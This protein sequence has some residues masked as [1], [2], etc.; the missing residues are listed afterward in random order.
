MI[1]L[2]S[3]RLGLSASLVLTVHRMACHGLKSLHG[4]SDREQVMMERGLTHDWDALSMTVS[5]DK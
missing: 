3:S 4:V 2:H 1:D 5:S